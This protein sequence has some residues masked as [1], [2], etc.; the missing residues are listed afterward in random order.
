MEDLEEERK[1]TNEAFGAELKTIFERM[2]KERGT[3]EKEK[4][5]WR[6]K[7][8]VEAAEK[9]E[10]ASERRELEKKRDE[11]KKSWDKGND[12]AQRRIADLE[13]QNRTLKGEAAERQ[14]EEAEAKTARKGVEAENNQEQK[15]CMEEARQEGRKTV[16]KLE[17]EV[18][19]GRKL[20]E[21]LQADKWRDRQTLLELRALLARSSHAATPSK[22]NSFR[23]GGS[24]SQFMGPQAIAG[25]SALAYTG[26]PAFPISNL[27][28]QQGFAAPAAKT[29]LTSPTPIVRLPSSGFASSA[30]T[31]P[32]FP[33]P[34]VRLPSRL[35][36]I[37]VPSPPPNA[38][39]GPKN[40]RSG[41]V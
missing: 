26:R 5:T 7:R 16:D 3:W 25:P 40:G 15:R 30:E 36:H 31:P 20:I 35:P 9:D 11:E 34:I 21:D 39:K 41:P 32:T 14:K 17:K 33:Q 23:V 19:N 38:P 27:P 13:E 8:D 4:M 29:P 18:F 2:K 10:R 37:P 28:S 22:M 12:R 1:R 24:A 6:E